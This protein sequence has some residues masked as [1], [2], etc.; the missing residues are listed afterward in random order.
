[1]KD[2]GNPVWKEQPPALT[3][4]RLLAGIGAVALTPVL[5][6]ASAAG[7]AHHTVMIEGLMFKPPQLSVKRGD[8]ITWVNKDPFPHTVTADGA[9]DS[10]EIAPD[11]SWSYVA[12]KAGNYA[13][14]C[15][16]HNTMTAHLI[17]S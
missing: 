11:K 1:M 8:R 13:Y 6:A 5:R 7:G 9:F 3:R 17:V 14:R 2:H 10:H 12:N 4:R 15:T 16:L